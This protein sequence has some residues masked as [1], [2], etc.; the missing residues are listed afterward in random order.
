MC[1]NQNLEKLIPGA[2]IHEITNHLD[3]VN[4]HAILFDFN[5]L[6]LIF[7]GQFLF[8]WHLKNGDFGAREKLGY[9]CI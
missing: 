8:L 3:Q 6:I 7:H 9:L 5:A 4:P 2:T 1:L